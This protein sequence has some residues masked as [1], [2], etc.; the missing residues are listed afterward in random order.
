MSEGKVNWHYT[1]PKC[2]NIYSYSMIAGDRIMLCKKCK[3]E[4]YE[5]AIKKNV[6]ST[7]EGSLIYFSVE[8]NQYSA[9]W[10]IINGMDEGSIELEGIKDG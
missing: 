9:H 1:C 6:G 7:V 10:D 5:K 4:I 8:Q 2:N 3:K